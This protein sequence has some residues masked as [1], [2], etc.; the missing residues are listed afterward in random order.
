MRILDFSA[1]FNCFELHTYP[2][3]GIV[4]TSLAVVLSIVFSWH[5][6]CVLVNN[7]TI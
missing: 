3:A 7:S 1:N 5:S 4:F 6:F 2:T